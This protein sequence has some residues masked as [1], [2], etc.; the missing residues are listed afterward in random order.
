MFLAEVVL[1]PARR[2]VCEHDMNRDRHAFFPGQCFHDGRRVG[3]ATPRRDAGLAFP[4]LGGFLVDRSWLLALGEPPMI[5]IAQKSPVLV[6]L[7]AQNDGAIART[8]HLGHFPGGSNQC[9]SSPRTPP[10]HLPVKHRAFKQI[11]TRVD[12]GPEIAPERARPHMEHL[13]TRVLAVV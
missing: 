11:Q 6:V 1:D 3:S 9:P 5:G 12:H 13:L 7:R 8:S 4:C 2:V 10:Q